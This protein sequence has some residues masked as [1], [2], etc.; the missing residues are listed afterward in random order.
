MSEWIL[1]VILH[2]AKCT[3]WYMLNSS[4]SLSGLYLKDFKICLL[5]MTVVCL[6]YIACIC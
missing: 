3:N 4:C 1:G 2:G 6:L 5:M